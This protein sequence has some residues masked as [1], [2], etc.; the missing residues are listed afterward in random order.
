M[1]CPECFGEVLSFSEYRRVEVNKFIEGK[2]YSIPEMEILI[3]ETGSKVIELLHQCLN[4][5]LLNKGLAE[6]QLAN[7]TCYFIP[8]KPSDDLSYPKASLKKYGRRSLQLVGKN[9]DLSWHFAIEGTHSFIQPMHLQSLII[10]YLQG[11][12]FWLK[13]RSNIQGEEVWGVVGITRN[14]AICF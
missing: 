6:Y 3:K 13:K 9:L 7:G 14:G 4:K 12:V 8:W 11:M 5:F 10:L 1:A 2:E